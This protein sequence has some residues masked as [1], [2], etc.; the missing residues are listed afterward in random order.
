MK[1][2]ANRVLSLVLCIVLLLGVLP[3][4]AIAAAGAERAPTE[5]CA[6]AMTSIVLAEAYDSVASAQG[7]TIYLEKNLGPAYF[8]SVRKGDTLTMRIHVQKSGTY[9]WCMVTGWSSPHVN[10]TF[11]LIIDGQEAATIV[12]EVPGADWRTWLDTTPGTVSLTEGEHEVVIRFG[13]DGPNVYGMKF[14]PEGVDMK[15]EGGYATLNAENDNTP[16]QITTDY[17]VQFRAAVP[18]DNIT[19]GCPSYNNNK[20]SFRFE[21]FKWQESYDKTVSGTPVATETFM[22]FSD[23]ANLT[24]RFET[25]MP[26][27]E[28]VLRLTNISEDR[29]E[30]VGVWT[31]KTA[32]DHIRNYLAGVEIPNAARG[33]LH[34]IGTTD[35]PLGDISANL[36]EIPSYEEITDSQK[37][38]SAYGLP[39][40]SRYHTAAVMPDTWVFTDGLGRVSLTNADVGAPRSDKTVAMFYWNWHATFAKIRTA[41]NVQQYIDKQTA[42]GIPLADYLY[43]Y[44]HAGWLAK[45]HSVQYFWD[46]PIYGYYASDDPWVLRRQAELLAGAGVDVI[47]TD[48][49]NATLTWSDSYPILYKTW[50]GALSDGVDTPKI[51]N[52]MP[53]AAGNDTAVQ[54]REMYTNIYHDGNYRPLWFYW[55][56]KPML[57]AH[58]AASL[59]SSVLDRQIA[60]FFTFRSGQPDYFL[61]FTEYGTWGWLSTAAQARY[62][63]DNA[64][65]K[66]G[67]V[68]QTTVGV[69]MNADYDKMAL[70]AMSGHNIMGR[71][72][73][74]SDKDRYVTEGAEASKW[75]YNFAEQWA[76]ALKVDPKVVFVTGWNEWCASRY[77][78]WPDNPQTAVENAFPDQFNNEFSRDIEPSKGA[79]KDH[80]YYQLVNFVRQ[81]KGARP[82]PTPSV[83]TVIDLTAGNDQWQAVEPYY[84]SYIGNTGDRDAAGYKGLSYT[85]TSGR[86]DIIGAQVARDDEFVYFHVECAEDI[87]PYTDKLWMNLYIDVTGNGAL[88]G[89]NSFDYVVNKTAPTA[90]TAVLEKFTGEG[91]AS[92]KVADVAYKLDGRYLTVKIAKSALG[93]SGDDYTVNFAWTDNVHDEGNY[94][95]YSGD[96]MD[97]YISGDVAPG[98]RFKYAFISTAENSGEDVP[99]E[100]TPSETETDAPEETQAPEGTTPE[101]P[102]ETGAETDATDDGGCASTVGMSAALL[103]T[104]CGAAVAL[105]RRKE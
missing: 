63:K 104:L 87:T 19:V 10:G 52:Y 4:A 43:D 91:Y 95:A 102:T 51:S 94:D 37:D 88:D 101:T 68:E 62:Y 16:I 20:G 72:Y 59:G 27:G 28:Y 70:A 64:A 7:N 49:T 99:A 71:S 23:N 44:D 8:D 25:A 36:E 26:L 21:L 80:Y 42:A 33:T 5:I 22:D 96:I 29:S 18:F 60:E 81:Y 17:A 67:V 12:N 46:E 76:Y 38:L 24:M 105:R 74:K 86:N 65:R 1:L 54:L 66:D 40:A 9:N 57:A 97:F 56:G 11:T 53:F 31:S 77:A 34:Y 35:K 85:E 93:L 78:S 14:A 58:G 30:Q 89:W 48:N 100:S 32:P 75:G 69:A 45:D 47:F 98:G 84:A 39:A 92:E 15:A 90:T 2:K 61:K 13:S 79:L 82:I 41:F 73:T 83:K 55:E 6:D 50:M 3:A 103:L